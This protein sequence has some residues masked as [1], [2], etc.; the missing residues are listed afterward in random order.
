MSIR[1]CPACG[2]SGEHE[3][4][5]SLDEM[6]SFIRCG[7]CNG[8]GWVDALPEKPAWP[9]FINPPP[10]YYERVYRRCL[11]P[12]ERLCRWITHNPDGSKRK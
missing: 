4:T 3:T 6:R 10:E 8:R 12:F 1:E 2:G 11:N 7:A 5:C 9:S